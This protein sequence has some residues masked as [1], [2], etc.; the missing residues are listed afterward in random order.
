MKLY[1]YEDAPF[2]PQGE[3]VGNK[4]QHTDCMSLV[5]WRFSKGHIGAMH[6]HP[7]EQVSYVLQGLV[8]FKTNTGSLVA[9]AGDQVLFA[10]HEAHG[11]TAL[12]DSVVLDIFSSV[13]EDFKGKFDEL[14]P[15]RSV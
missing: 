4:V 7:Q 2:T 1:H 8:E 14:A 15:V 9:K 5:T 11:S 13:R 12:E 6:A 10:G 3:T